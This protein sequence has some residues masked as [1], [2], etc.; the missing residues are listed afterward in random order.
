MVQDESAGAI[1]GSRIEAAGRTVPLR[2][3]LSGALGV[4]VFL[5]ISINSWGGG[6]V[7]FAAVVTAVVTG[8]SL[9]SIYAMAAS[10]I[11]VT[12]TTTGIFNFAQG[13]IGTLLAFIFWELSVNRG[14]PEFPALILVVFVIAPI[15]GAGLDFIL[16]RRLVG[17][18]LVVQLVVTIGLMFGLM[19][20]I[21]SIWDPIEIRTT[22]FFFGL[23]GIKISDTTVPYHR[24]LAVALALALAVGLRL[25]LHRSRIGV[26]MRAVVDNPALA[27]LHGARPARVSMLAWA[28]STSMSALAGIMLAPE[29]GV[30]VEAMALLTISCFAPAIIGRLKSLPLTFAGAMALGLLI[31]FTKTW[32]STTGRW[33]FLP[34][35]IPSIMLLVALL[36]LP[37]SRI[38]YARAGGRGEPKA[39]RATPIPEAMIGLAIFILAV[40]LISLP[41]DIKN[42][43]LLSVAV[44]TALL[45]MSYIP[46]TGW[47]GQVSLAQITFA[48]IGA[49][50]MWKLGEDTAN[51]MIL[52]VCALVAVPFG[53]LM[54]LPA[55]RLHGLYLALASLAF[56]FLGEYLLFGQPEIFSSA[57]R[58]I[59]KRPD[60][61]GMDMSSPD[62]QRTFLM[63]G[64]VLLAI[65]GI[66][67][68]WLRRSRFGRRL[69]ALRDSE[70]ACVT[71]GVNPIVTKL[72]VYGLSAAIAG[73][74]GG[75]F[76]LQRSG[77][78]ATNYAMLAGV[79]FLLLVVVGG[80]E[81][82]GGAVF[83]GAIS[84]LLLFVKDTWEL[85]FLN[86]LEILG[87]G[88]LA[89][90]V[91]N[92][93]D[94]SLGEI[95]KALA[96]LL[97]WRHD[98]KEERAVD[99]AKKQYAKEQRRALQAA[100][101]SAAASSNGVGAVK[102]EQR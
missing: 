24:I 72:W 63:F 27:A 91:A 42:L 59:K 60:V 92:T 29:T 18:T 50:T 6:E 65:V 94:G 36:A 51:P 46:L 52:L 5:A 66:G 39:K 64:L 11:V 98:A 47:A 102:V 49:F 99:K 48:G 37:Q 9:G 56:A 95:G 43:N 89:L 69:V 15:I 93:P 4:L 28:L 77:A 45:L 54:A 17:S 32:L 1:G 76:A 25:L 88:L 82:M 78:E 96:P 84:V 16:M 26:T 57:G 73:F 61:L 79:G 2:T 19:G 30:G 81:L 14:L 101:E 70:A 40:G 13:A 20:L 31:T 8:I 23:N 86:Y 3:V 75:M 87:P 58:I 34:A 62:H 90:G 41:M 71:F 67:I 97:P 100:D 38:Q 10:G 74:A 55:L 44:V 12:H 35:A 22:P 21:P 83:G 7:T 80:V 85:S 33:N 68:L 53:C